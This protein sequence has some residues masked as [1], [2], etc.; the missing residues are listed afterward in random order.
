MIGEKPNENCIVMMEN[1]VSDGKREIQRIRVYGRINLFT[2]Q[3]I[4]MQ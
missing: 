3:F 2:L 4:S 1:I